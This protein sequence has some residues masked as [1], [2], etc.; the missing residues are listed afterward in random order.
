MK[1]LLVLMVGILLMTAMARAEM[2]RVQDFNLC[3]KTLGQWEPFAKYKGS[4]NA[5]CQRFR[6][7]TVGCAMDMVDMG[8][9]RDIFEGIDYCFFPFPDYRR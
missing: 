4:S 8:Q 6:M 2:D 9:A 5:I 1:K 7:R 3:V